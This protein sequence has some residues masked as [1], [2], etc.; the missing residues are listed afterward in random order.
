M[1]KMILLF[2]FIT[3]GLSN[4]NQEDMEM[5][6]KDV[7]KAFSDSFMTS[8]N[9]FTEPMSNSDFYPMSKSKEMNMKTNRTNSGVINDETMAKNLTRKLKIWRGFSPISAMSEEVKMDVDDLIST[10]ND[11][12]SSVRESFVNSTIQMHQLGLLP[13]RCLNMISSSKIKIDGSEV[14]MAEI[15][16]KYPLSIA[17]LYK[18]LILL[19]NSN[20]DKREELLARLHVPSFLEDD[21]GYAVGY[22]WTLEADDLPL[23][24]LLKFPADAIV[25]MKEESFEV[26]K[27]P[28]KLAD[29]EEFSRASLQTKVAWFSKF[30]AQSG[31]EKITESEEDFKHHAHLVA[32]APLDF[33]Q[34]FKNK[35]INQNLLAGLVNFT[36]FDPSRVNFVP[37]NMTTNFCNSRLRSCGRLW[38]A[39][40]KSRSSTLKPINWTFLK[41]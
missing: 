18:V 34:T 33:L 38:K 27:M 26:L 13:N 32:G 20:K 15:L 41:L 35:S 29:Q 17:L 5:K 2:L 8:K 4:P 23:K 24:T 25:N 39:P 36:D 28:I 16:K 11:V 3:R 40:R 12:P 30:L 21:L 10:F 19:R 9:D 7:L 6:N 37:V 22:R 14:E 31:W 1:E